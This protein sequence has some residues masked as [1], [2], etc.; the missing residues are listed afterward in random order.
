[1]VSSN[2]A[3]IDIY[4]GFGNKYI[5]ISYKAAVRHAITAPYF[6]IV[7]YGKTKW[8]GHRIP[9]R[10]LHLS[11]CLAEAGQYTDE[12]KSGETWARIV[13]N[14]CSGPKSYFRTEVSPQCCTTSTTEPYFRIAAASHSGPHLRYLIP[15]AGYKARKDASGAARCRIVANLFSGLANKLSRNRLFESRLY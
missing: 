8:V 9:Y 4:E 6:R 11:Y 12:D 14:L 7:V 13:A 15:T 5:A 1:M 2:V 3:Y 10:G